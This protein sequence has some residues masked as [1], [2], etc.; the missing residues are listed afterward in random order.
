MPKYDKSA[1]ARLILSGIEGDTE[2]VNLI[3]SEPC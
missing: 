1:T 2:Y 3:I